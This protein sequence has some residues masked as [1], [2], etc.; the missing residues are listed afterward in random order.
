MGKL[1]DKVTIIT[2]GVSGIGAAT[3]ELFGQEGAKLVLV[4]QNYGKGKKFEQKLVSKGYDVIFIHADVTNEEQAQNVFKVAKE[5]FGPVGILFNNAG[6]GYAKPTEEITYAEYR[7]T[8]EIDL[9]AYFLYSQLAIKDMLK[10]RGGVIVNTAAIRGI[11]GGVK[12]AALSAAKGGVIN[13]TRALALEFADR[14]IRVNALCPGYTNTPGLGVPEVMKTTLAATI[15]MK[16]LGTAEE[17]AKAALFLACDDS[18]FM[19]GN[20]LTIDGGYTA[21]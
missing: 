9:D 6:V 1:Q 8:V 13:L 20:T 16:R 10:N 2:G 4:D 5:K 19:T 7:R 12:L 3:A 15:P 21:Q 11:V 17:M 18:S 14:H